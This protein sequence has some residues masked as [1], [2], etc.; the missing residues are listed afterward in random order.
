MAVPSCP[1]TVVAVGTL[2]SG[3]VVAAGVSVEP[4]SAVVAGVLVDPGTAVDVG[5]YVGV[6][7]AVGPGVEVGIGVDVAGRVGVGTGVVEEDDPL[8]GQ[9]MPLQCLMSLFTTNSAT[10]CPIALR[11]MMLPFVECTPPLV[12]P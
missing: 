10:G 9:M 8:P 2:V 1:A 5:V 12:K 11:S 7:E 4:G 3:P 6:G